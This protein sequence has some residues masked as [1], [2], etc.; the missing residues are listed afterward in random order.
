MLRVEVFAWL[1]LVGAVRRCR[2]QG[3][4]LHFLCSLSFG[5]WCVFGI[6]RLL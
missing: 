6:L 5:Y 1:L 4:T 3:C 2:W